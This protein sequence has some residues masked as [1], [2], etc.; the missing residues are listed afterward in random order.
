[1][2]YKP[3]NR[4]YHI[5]YDNFL[6]R[7]GRIGRLVLRIADDYSDIDV[8]A[9]NDPFI[10]LD[11]MVLSKLFDLWRRSAF[12]PNHFL[13]RLI[14]LSMILPMEGLKEM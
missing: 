3:T 5:N 10:G 1:L 11:D 8:V 12:S 14:C 13:H 2:C 6:Y 7:F 4:V 9:I